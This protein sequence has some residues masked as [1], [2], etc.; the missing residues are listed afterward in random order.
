MSVLPTKPTLEGYIQFCQ[1]VVGIPLEV[2]PSD[3]IQYQISYEVAL[4]L[5]PYE[6]MAQM[7]PQIA[8]LCVYYWGASVLINYGQDNPNAEPPN[9]TY[10]QSA[11]TSFGVGNFVAGVITSASDQGTSE[12][13][14]VGQGLQNLTLTDLE[15]LKDPYGRQALA[16][17]QSIG[18]LWGLS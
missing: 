7:S 18:T 15:R 14:A 10:F 5:V 13:M 8:T 3:S 2:L 9:N 11:R 6:Y 12:S 16:W 1:T 4:Q 17:M